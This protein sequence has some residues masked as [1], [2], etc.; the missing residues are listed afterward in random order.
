MI[1]KKITVFGR[2]YILEEKE[3][4]IL[5][6]N[7]QEFKP[8]IEQAVGKHYKICIED[9]WLDGLIT[10]TGI[11]IDGEEINGII[12][13]HLERPRKGG[14]AAEGREIIIQ[15]PIPGK[16]TRIF[17]KEGEE[18]EQNQE[19]FI[20]EAMKMRNRILSPAKGKVKEILIEK[21]QNVNQDEILA[22][23]T[24]E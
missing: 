2:E 10:E 21:N 16:I 9:T 4:G 24:Q 22:R 6:V 7:G 23:I 12:M 13:P 3:N 11:L 18:I 15:A 14:L 5:V 20:L 8:R 17:V 19:L 1:K